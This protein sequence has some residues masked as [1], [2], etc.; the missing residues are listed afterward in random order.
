MEMGIVLLHILIHGMLEVGVH[1]VLLA[2]VEHKQ[3]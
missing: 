2:V 3:G 1:A